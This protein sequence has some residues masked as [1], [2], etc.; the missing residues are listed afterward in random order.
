MSRDPRPW[1]VWWADVAFEDQPERTKRRPVLVLDRQTCI[2]LSLKITSHAPREGFL[3]EYALQKW[4]AA[5]LSKPSTVRI[6]KVLRLR[7]N[8]FAEK[9]GNLHPIDIHVVEHYLSMMYHC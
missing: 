8:D 6:S 1:E 9:I 2:V 4:R 3:G 5:G 7:Q